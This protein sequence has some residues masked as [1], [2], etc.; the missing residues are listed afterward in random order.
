M[1]NCS[2]ACQLSIA[3]HEYENMS[4]LFL[5]LNRTFNNSLQ[6]EFNSIIH[7]FSNAKNKQILTSAYLLFDV[8]M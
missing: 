7:K 1:L 5:T 6:S 4:S 8:F 2:Q 3:V